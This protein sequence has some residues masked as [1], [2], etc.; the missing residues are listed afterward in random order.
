[1]DPYK[2]LGVSRDASDD[3][4]K[5][6]YHRMA[7]K[8]HP[9]SGGDAWAFVQV[10]EAYDTLKSR[11]STSSRTA[12]EPKPSRPSTKPTK[13][14]AAKANTTKATGQTPTSPLRRIRKIFFSELPLQ[15]ETTT[16]ILVSVLDIFMT[17]VL[18]RFGGREANPIANLFLT[19]GGIPAMVLWKMATVAFVASIAQVVAT[20]NLRRAKSLLHLATAIVGCVVVYGL[21][22]FWRHIS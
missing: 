16:F 9:D 4:I 1:M 19:L 15:T 8:Y 5:R 3:D 18:L 22:L 14:N 7:Q 13:S 20:K 11:G 10:Q 21:I 2:I 12:S 6:A 17:Y